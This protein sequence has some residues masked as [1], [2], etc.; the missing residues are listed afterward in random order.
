M[1]NRIIF[2]LP[3]LLWLQTS[4]VAQDVV[5]CTQLLEDAREAY[6]AGMV[7]LVPEL[8]L[9]CI[10][11]SG[12]SGTAREEA[13]KLIINAYLFDYLPDEADKLM[14]AFL[15][16]NPNYEAQA[17]DPSEFKLLLETHKERRA[18]EAAALVAAARTRQLEE[19]AAQQ[20]AAE[21]SK[22]QKKAGANSALDSDKPRIGFQVGVSGSKGAIMEPYSVGDPN[23]EDGKYAFAPGFVLGAKVDLPLSKGIEIGLG[24]LYNRVNLS[25]SASPYDF[26]SY[27]YHESENKIQLP[28]SML[29]YLNPKGQTRAYL[30]VGVVADYLFSASAYGTRTY[31]ETDSYLKDVEVEKMSI[32]D[33][34]SRM[35]MQGLLGVGVN[36]P[37]QNAFLSIEACYSAG[38]L[39]TN[40]SEY[41]Y[42][43]QDILWILYQ[44]DSDFRVNQL[45]LNVGMTWNL[46]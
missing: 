44:V 32:S 20:Q 1:N 27:T 2:I 19:Q 42:D 9:P 38:F 12:F 6:A 17:S 40:K 34:R 23:S 7:E 46:N 36:I 45:L 21:Q 41:R 18:E 39:Q 22:A 43:N 15:D 16:E 14:S 26:T 8:L 31:E 10:E 11:E 29:V 24:L 33:T 28:V 30:R 37:L 3:L 4:L 25:Y 35:N 5:G 13:Y